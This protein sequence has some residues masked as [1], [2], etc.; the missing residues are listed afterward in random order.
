MPHLVGPS[1]SSHEVNKGLANM[2]QLELQTF[3]E[4]QRPKER[5]QQDAAFACLSSAVKSPFFANHTHRDPAVPM[6]VICVEDY[7]ELSATAGRIIVELIRAKPAC[8][9]GLATGSTPLGTYQYLVESFRAGEISFKEVKTFNLDEYCELP[10]SHPQS[11]YRFMHDNLFR[12]VDLRPENIHIP[13]TEGSELQ[14]QCDSYNA[15]LNSNVIDLQLLGIG[16]NG[17]IGFC[18]PG[19]PFSQETFLTRL[20]DK[21]R[22]DNKRFFNSL[23]EVPTTA[24]TMGIKNILQARSILLIASGSTKAESVAQMINGPISEQLPASA[25]RQ[26]PDV[27]VIV[28]KE[29][30]ALL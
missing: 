10:R 21:T 26:H 30:A 17:H 4:N 25:L 14:E 23:D 15:L 28:D 5:I 24:V 22:E 1:R 7:A 6:K 27:T 20:S 13:C 9:L 3:A 8:T 29:A 18:E 11:Y 12:H 19:T 2:A 16:S